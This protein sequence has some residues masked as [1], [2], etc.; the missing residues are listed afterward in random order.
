MCCFFDQF[1]LT[2]GCLSCC[3]LVCFM[4]QELQ[5]EFLQLVFIIEGFRNGQ[6]QGNL[7]EL[8]KK[9]AATLDLIV[10]VAYTEQ[11]KIHVAGPNQIGVKALALLGKD[12][13]FLLFNN[14]PVPKG[15]ETFPSWS[16]KLCE[17][18]QKLKEQYQNLKG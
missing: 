16:S 9:N 2:G 1:F 17:Q 10:N 6:T 8:M 18:Y 11:R 4:A 14:L 7:V 5:P 15:A 13:M 12:D 3:F